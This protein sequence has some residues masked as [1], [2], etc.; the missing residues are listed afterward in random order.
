MKRLQLLAYS[1]AVRCFGINHVSN[2]KVRVIRLLEEVAEAAQSIDVDRE[3]I[4]QVL[5]IV[6]SRPKGEF[7]Q[8][9]GGIAMTFAV[10]CETSNYQIPDLLMV[11]FNRV[12]SKPIKL[13]SDRNL[14]KVQVE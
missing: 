7:S 4:N 13:F 9:M 3:T 11:E 12:V 14:E 10:L 6:Y 5:D 2:R 1:W 8:E